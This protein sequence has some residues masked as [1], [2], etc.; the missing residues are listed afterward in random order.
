MPGG[1]IPAHAGKTA[2]VV[3]EVAEGHG[4]SPLTR[5]KPGKS[6][7]LRAIMGLIPA[8][9]GK[10]TLGTLTRLA[11][12]AH[13]RSRGEN[14]RPGRPCA[15]PTGSSP[16]TRGKLEAFAAG[17]DIYGLIPAH[18]GKTA[19]STGTVRTPRA[20]PRSRGENGSPTRVRLGTSG[21]SPLT[22]GKLARTRAAPTGGGLI[23]AHAGKTFFDSLAKSCE[24]AHPRSRGENIQSP[25]Q[26]VK[27]S[28]SSPLT[29]GKRGRWPHKESCAGLIPAHAGKTNG[30]L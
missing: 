19:A 9:A 15:H 30:A 27:T 18:A 12:R 24:G 25:S 6:F 10:T 17:R 23:P 8:H 1:L 26:T 28:G 5:G 29:R 20:H 21:S 14:V 4:S 13:P 11:H 3:V 7:L 22:R 2:L 16:L